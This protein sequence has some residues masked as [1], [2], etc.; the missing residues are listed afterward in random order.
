MQR[1]IESSVNAVR[2]SVF[3]LVVSAVAVVSSERMFWF[4]AP[5]LSDY[6]IGV[7]F[8]AVPTAVVLA[9]I[10]RYRVSDWR[11]LLLVTPIFAY[12]VEG[13]ITP[14][15]YTGGPF[16]PFFPAWFGF[17]HGIMSF[18]I[19]V[20]A[21]RRWIVAGAARPLLLA[22]AGMGAFW[23]VWSS[24]LRLPENVN[25]SE[26]IDDLGELV[27]LDPTAFAGYAVTF[28]GVVMV[29]HWALGWLWPQRFQVGRQMTRIGFVLCLI[30]VVG[31]TVVIPWALTM[32]T[33]YAGLQIWGLR[34]HR[35]AIQGAEARG[36]FVPDLIAQLHGRVT[37][38]SVLPVLSMGPTAALVYA[39]ISAVDPSIRTLQVIMYGSITVQ[40]LVGGW[41]TIRS[42]LACRRHADPGSHPQ[43]NQDRGGTGLDY[44][45][46]G[47]DGGLQLDA[48]AATGIH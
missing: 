3:V 6:A 12:L 36:T 44:V 8:Y 46:R 7:V 15:M 38:R 40:T 27:V 16:I 31:W 43:P 2:M 18:A 9:M 19:L 33:A 1:L 42:L 24:T 28:T 22:S 35:H 37:V 10:G 48:A 41:L 25:D 47:G 13:W 34:R 20:V 39:M 14:V 17:W 23:G 30:G 11:S 29:L 21:F 45:D 4:W 5:S 32:F 26:M